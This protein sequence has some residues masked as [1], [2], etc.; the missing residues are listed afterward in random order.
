[1][2][3]T[4]A[5]S[6]AASVDT[7]DYVSVGLINYPIDILV[8][9]NSV[10][11]QDAGN[12]R[13]WTAA[14]TSTTSAP[15]S[16]TARTTT[17]APAITTGTAARTTAKS[18]RLINYPIDTRIAKNS[19][20]QDAGNTGNDGGWT[21]ILTSTTRAPKSSTARTTTTGPAKTTGTAARST[22]EESP[23]PQTDKNTRGGRDMTQLASVQTFLTNM[24]AY[25]PYGIGLIVAFTLGIAAAML[26]ATICCCVPR[27][28]HRRMCRRTDVNLP[29]V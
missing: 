2:F 17:I 20:Q 15:K 25:L 5:H 23:R 1:M 13:G 6:T 22:T 7:S 14:L 26:C 4:L 10:Q 11:Q 27:M 16:S 28:Y 29:G 24:E 3:V 18:P 12:D 8:D 9:K 21:A 19:V